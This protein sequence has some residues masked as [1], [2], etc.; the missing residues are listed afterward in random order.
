MPTFSANTYPIIRPARLRSS[1]HDGWSGGRE[2]AEQGL[3]RYCVNTGMATGVVGR[4]GYSVLGG[5]CGCVLARFICTALASAIPASGGIPVSA[6]TTTSAFG[7]LH[8]DDRR[9]HLR[10]LLGGVSVCPAHRS[11]PTMG[12]PQLSCGQSWLTSAL[13]G[14]PVSCTRPVVCALARR[15]TSRLTRLGVCLSAWTRAFPSS[16]ELLPA[17]RPGSARRFDT[18]LT[19]PDPSQ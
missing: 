8:H 11:A 5:E 16:V 4:E 12:K 15:A 10:P 18:R 6:R 17:P 2:S 1:S 19:P 7:A 9:P 3:A 13:S 14:I